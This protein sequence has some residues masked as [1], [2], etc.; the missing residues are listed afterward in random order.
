M[1]NSDDVKPGLRP[2]PALKARVTASSEPPKSVERRRLP[3][4][5][6]GEAGSVTPPERP[7]QVASAFPNG[8]TSSIF[9]RNDGLSDLVA[10]PPRTVP[11]ADCI[12]RD[13]DSSDS[14]RVSA[15]PP[16]SRLSSM[17]NRSFIKDI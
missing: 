14:P 17:L 10:M 12:P 13:T 1:V 2:V 15:I 16:S 7:D 6:K 8:T 3:V 5:I 9:R 4:D 11:I